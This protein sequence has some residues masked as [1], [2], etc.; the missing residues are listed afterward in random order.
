MFIQY[1]ALN[2][3]INVTTKNYVRMDYLYT[4]FKNNKDSM[5]KYTGLYSVLFKYIRILNNVF[6]KFIKHFYKLL[7][8]R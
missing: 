3:L 4:N 8:L 1:V 2:K 7:Y 6:Y 5:K